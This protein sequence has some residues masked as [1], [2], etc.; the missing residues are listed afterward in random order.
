M[1]IFSS[2]RKLEVQLPRFSLQQSN[3]LKMSLA[4][5]GI[6][7]VFESSADLSGISNA[8]GLKLSEV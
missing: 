4:S 3:S 6:K 5:L 1:C 8:E 7:E 2:F